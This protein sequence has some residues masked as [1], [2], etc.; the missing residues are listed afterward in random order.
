MV[1]EHIKK[2]HNKTLLLYHIVC[3]VKDRRKTLNNEVEQT[4]KQL[5]L[6]IQERYEIHFIEIGT[7]KD[8]VHFLT[9]SIPTLSPKQIVQIIKS[10]TAR[11]LFKQ[12]PEIKKMLWGGE[13]WTK[14][15]Y[16]N[17][18]GQ[19]TNEQMIKNYIQKQN[20]TYKQLHRS[21]LILFNQ[22]LE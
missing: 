13:F 2:S 18:V 17:T 10:I 19:Y 21:Q 9:Q 22:Q 15:Y 8:H 11:E 20:K 14:G 1:A 3:P 5:C 6:E 4:L 12:H 16:V 7:D